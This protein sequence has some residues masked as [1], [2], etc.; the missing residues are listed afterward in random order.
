VARIFISHSSR[1]EAAAGRIIAWLK[2]QGFEEVFLDID[3]HAGIPPGAAWERTLYRE[4][5]R[6][7][8][9]ILIVTANWHA[10]RWCWA[11]FTQARALGKAIF[12]IIEAPTGE[13]LVAPDIQHL[14]LTS[15]RE[16]GLERLA[17]ALDAIARE[18]HDFPFDAGRP[19]YPGLLAL[20][21]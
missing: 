21:E 3:K 6:A 16:G 1:D 11:E 15:D 13:T 19:P 2:G 10:S 5:A 14:D 17:R 4:I 12:P 8:A 7:H 20:Q 18:Q 9:V